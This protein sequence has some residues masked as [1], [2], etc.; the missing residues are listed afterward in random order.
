MTTATKTHSV[1][2][3]RT[4]NSK[5]TWRVYRTHTV[6]RNVTGMQG[7]GEVTGYYAEN[8]DTGERVT[9]SSSTA[10]YREVPGY[11]PK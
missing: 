4:T 9:V 3:T 1:P 10:A 2:V 5:G 8:M 7:M 11:E 6:G